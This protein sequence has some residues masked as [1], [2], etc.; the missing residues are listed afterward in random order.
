MAVQ[1]ACAE[2]IRTGD[3]ANACAS[4]CPAAPADTDARWMHDGAEFPWGTAAPASMSKTFVR[5]DQ[6]AMPV[7]PQLTPWW[8]TLNDPLLDQLIT[9]A[10]SSNPSIE[11]AEARVR[12]ARSQMRGARAALAPV[13]GAGAGAGN[14]Q[15]PGLVTGGEAKSSSDRKSTRLNSSH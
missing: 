2:A 9:R 8:R 7:P 10:L 13:V 3:S 15:A 4:S 6:A 5:A 11:V 14:I 1:R 12:Q